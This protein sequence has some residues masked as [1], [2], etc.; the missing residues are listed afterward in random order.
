ML[1]IIRKKFFFGINESFILFNKSAI[2][3]CDSV[4]FFSCIFVLLD[5]LMHNFDYFNY[6]V[7]FV[8]CFCDFNTILMVCFCII[9]I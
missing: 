2:F 6:F 1:D 7:I 4:F 8:I 9:S 5:F 3:N